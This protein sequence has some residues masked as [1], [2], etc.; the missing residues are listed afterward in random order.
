MHRVSVRKGSDR[1][2]ADHGWLRSWHTFSFASYSNSNHI[3]FR[4]LRVMNEDIVAPSAGFGTH[5]HNDMEI[6]TLVLSGAL[7]HQDS[8]GNGQILVPGE[9]QRMS[10]GTGLTHSEFNPSSDTP[11][12][13]Y[14]IWLYPERKGLTPSWEQRAFDPK[15]RMNRWQ[16]VASRDQREGS[17]LIHQ[18]ANLFLTN[19][20]PQSKIAADIAMGRAAWLQVLKGTAKI[21]GESLVAG[22]GISVED[23]P[24]IEIHTD[25]GAEL[26]W[27]DLA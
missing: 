22:D 15:L 7:K 13:L 5:P 4:S 6:V 14:Q 16:I 24:S 1:G 27:F 9:L 18:D 25:D 26:L 2:F 8:M 20:L 23:A 3:R 19:L 17:L 12:H 10:A 21:L 11:L